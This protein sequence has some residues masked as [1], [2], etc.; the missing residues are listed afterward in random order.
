MICL[1]VTAGSFAVNTFTKD[2]SALHVRMRMDN[3]T[4]VAYVNHIGGTRSTVL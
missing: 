2:R 1:E 4:A 3:S